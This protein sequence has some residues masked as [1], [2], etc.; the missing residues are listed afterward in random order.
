MYINDAANAVFLVVQIVRMP[1][2]AHMITFNEST[3]SIQLMCSLNIDIPSSVTV[4]WLHNG[5]DVVTTSDEIMTA[6]NTTTLII[7]KPQ[8]S[9]AGVYR[10][11]FNDTIGMW[12]LE[13]NLCKD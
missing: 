10:C 6:G 4:I 7:A 5:S 1:T 2:D 13:R 3:S 8:P 9:D 11:V 12:T